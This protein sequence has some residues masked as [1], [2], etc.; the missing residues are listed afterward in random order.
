MPRLWKPTKKRR[1]PVF[2]RLLRFAAALPLL[3]IPLIPATATAAGSTTIT[4]TGMTVV[5][6]G[7]KLAGVTVVV[8]LKLECAPLPPFGFGFANLSLL[9]ASPARAANGQGGTF[10]QPGF[11]VTCDGVTFNSLAIAVNPNQFSS[12]FHPGPATANFSAQ[13]CSFSGFPSFSFTCDSASNASF[14]ILIS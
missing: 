14:Q 12:P 5:F 6:S 11:N 4:G 3:A 8:P 10:L 1:D 13:I 2:R 7:A 9:Q